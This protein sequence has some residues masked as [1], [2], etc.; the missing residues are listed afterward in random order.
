MDGSRRTTARGDGRGRVRLSLSRADAGERGMGGVRVLRARDDARGDGVRLGRGGGRRRQ[1][2]VPG[3]RRDR[4]GSRWIPG[5]G[6]VEV[7][8]VR[9]GDGQAVLVDH[10]TARVG[11]GGGG[12]VVQVRHEHGRRLEVDDAVAADLDLLE[13]R[14]VEGERLLRRRAG[15]GRR[16]RRR[17]GR[18]S[19]SRLAVQRTASIFGVHRT[20][21]SKQQIASHEGAATLHALE[22]A[23]LGVCTAGSASCS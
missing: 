8:R 7:R 15:C 6:R 3:A 17:L 20:I 9:L 22:R 12:L 5:H 21:M 4:D 13:R 1:K 11:D 2:R 19:S 14:G 23:F 18:T 10:P 16:R